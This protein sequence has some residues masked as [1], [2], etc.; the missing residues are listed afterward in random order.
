MGAT[1]VGIKGYDDQ[2][3]DLSAEGFAALADLDRQALAALDAATP[4]SERELVAKE[5]MQERL[6]L[7]VERYDAGEA[8]S[9]L[10]VI[11]SSLHNIR[12]VFDLMPLTGSDAAANIAA[13]LAA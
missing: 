2:L 12:G 4:E 6:G 1:Y 9:E 3:T 7:S 11:A 10:N 5:A 8:T 13:R